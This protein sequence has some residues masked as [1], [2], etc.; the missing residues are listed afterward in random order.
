MS[1]RIVNPLTMLLSGLLIGFISRLLDIFTTNLGEIFS[2]MAIWILMGTLISIY[3]K[4]ANKSNAECF[5]ILPGDA[6]YI[7]LSCGFKSRRVF[8]QL[9]NR[10]DRV[11]VVFAFYGFFRMVYK[12]KRSISENRQRGNNCGFLSVIRIIV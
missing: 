6:Y 9:H 7:L 2:Q 10:L 1:K 3:S 12:R 4:T 5:D 8:S 11:C